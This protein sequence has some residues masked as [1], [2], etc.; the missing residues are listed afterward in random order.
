MPKL[1]KRPAIKDYRNGIAYIPLGRYISHGF[2]VIDIEDAEHIEKYWWHKD[3][4]GYAVTGTG[5]KRG[6]AN[7]YMHSLICPV[8]KPLVTDHI[9]RDVRNNRR[10][11]L[12]AVTFSGNMM[13][14]ATRTDNQWGKITA[15]YKGVSFV[16]KSK[17]RPW[18]YALQ[19]NGKKYYGYVATEEEAAIGYNLLALEHHK[20]LAE[21]NEVNI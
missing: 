1:P 7:I 5:V 4:N 3:T 9:D 14:K 13:N 11:N 19:K 10:S 16:K 2:A 18:Q 8:S 15:K 6:E 17:K 12:R 21:L 20:E